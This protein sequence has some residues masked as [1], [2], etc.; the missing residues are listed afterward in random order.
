TAPQKMALG[1][2]KTKN[3]SP[4]S[5]SN[6]VSDYFFRV[7]NE[8]SYKLTKK[9]LVNK[10]LLE[11]AGK[12]AQVLT[13]DRNSCFGDYA[14]KGGNEPTL[15]QARQSNFHSILGSDGIQSLILT[16]RARA[17]CIKAT[18]M[19][20]LKLD[21]RVFSASSIIFGTAAEDE[22][23]IDNSKVEFYTKQG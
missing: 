14:K 10:S 16:G 8:L 20:A 9:W 15:E 19:D 21:Y 2:P 18:A 11:A 17:S 5:K 6:Q 4:Y 3:P 12:N 1:N 7:E 23:W 13:K 22:S